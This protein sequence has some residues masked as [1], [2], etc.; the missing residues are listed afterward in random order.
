MALL[1]FGTNLEN[2]KQPKMRNFI[3]LTMDGFTYDSNNQA[4]QNMQVLGAAK[5]EN[6]L[7]AFKNFKHDQSYLSRFSF[8]EVIALEYVGDF[9]RNLEL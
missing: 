2:N 8:K 6:I 5:G 7:K 4:I 3:F 9:I 1:S